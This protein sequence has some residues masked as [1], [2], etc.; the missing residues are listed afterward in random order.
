MVSNNISLIALTLCALCCLAVQASP[1]AVREVEQI[2]GDIQSR[3]SFCT[4]LVGIQC[5]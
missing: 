1:V 4:S 2:S 5:K 3:A